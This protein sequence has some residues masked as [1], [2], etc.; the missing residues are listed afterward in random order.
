MATM[1]FTQQLARFLPC[2]DQTVD[3]GSLRDAL[4]QAFIAN[5]RL[6]SY[7]VDEAGELRKHVAIFIDGVPARD[8]NGLTDPVKAHSEIYVLQALSG[9]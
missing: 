8:R 6:K 1:S 5:P 9:G 7:V 2:P 4:D 3:A